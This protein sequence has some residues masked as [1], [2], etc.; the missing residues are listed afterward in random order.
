MNKAFR[1]SY[2]LAAL[3]LFL[4]GETALAQAYPARTVR[5]IV[6]AAAGGGIDFTARLV[7]QKL[8]ERLDQPFV[9][10]NRGGA[11]GTIG[12]AVAAEAAPDGYT[13]LLGFVGPLAMAPHVIK[14]PY[15]PM[16]DLIGLSLLA[17]S[18][19]VI[20][21]HPSL[22]VRSVKQ[23]IAFAKARPGEL[24]YASAQIWNPSH[25][26]P[27]LFNKVTGIRAVPIHFKGMAPAVISVLTGEAPLIFGTV[28]TVVSHIRAGRLVALAVTSPERLPQVPEVP[29]LPEVG[30]RGVD[31]PL[32]YSLMAPGA[33]PRDIVAKLHG[34]LVA[35]NALPDYRAVLEKQ[36]LLRASMTPAQFAAFLRA[37][38]D[39]WGEVIRSIK[40][41]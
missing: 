16:K 20:A 13:L 7:A 34:E 38:Y 36:A 4:A 8:G 32:W 22:P 24:N 10:D 17:S 26:A 18:Y 29:T 3:G 11:G 23:L 41:N 31:V 6:A 33:T 28:T 19:H 14:V 21:V 2:A 27:E 35:I 37:E 5:I 15:D 12:T 30:V 25:L 40:R 1:W 39:K 9:V